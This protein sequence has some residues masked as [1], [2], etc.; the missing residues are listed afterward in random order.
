VSEQRVVA[1]KFA[2]AHDS[3][4]LDWIEKVRGFVGESKW[5]ITTCLLMLERRFPS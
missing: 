5:Q 1:S 4:R 2:E 3:K